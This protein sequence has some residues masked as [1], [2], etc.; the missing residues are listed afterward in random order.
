MLNKK[1]WC[2]FILAFLV[3]NS[4]IM[5]VNSYDFGF[6]EF[7]PGRSILHYSQIPSNLISATILVTLR[8]TR[9]FQTKI[10]TM[11]LQKN[12]KTCPAR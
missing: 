7:V 12:V 4:K 9:Q 2:D 3:E 10:R 6:G 8:P 11:N 5:G 1:F